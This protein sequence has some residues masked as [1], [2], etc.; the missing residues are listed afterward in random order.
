MK[1][2]FLI[3]ALVFILLVIVVLLIIY[4]PTEEEKDLGIRKRL[5]S[6][7]LQNQPQF[8]TP[9]QLEDLLKERGMDDE[10]LEEIRRQ[11]YQYPDFSR[12]LDKRMIDLINFWY[13]EAQPLP[14]ILNPN[15]RDEKKISDYIK[16]LQNEGKTES[17][18]QKLIEEEFKSYPTYI[19]QT[20]KHT[21]TKGDVLVATL[22]IFDSKGNLLPYDVIEAGIFADPYLKRIRL[23]TPEYNDSGIEPDE[24]KDDVYTF[25]WKIPSEDKKYWGNLTLKVKVYLQEYQNQFEISETFFSSPWVVAEFLDQF[26]EEIKDGHLYI[27]AFLKVNKECEYHIQANLFSVEFDEPTHWVTYKNIL[28]PGIHKITFQF[29]GKIFHDKEVEGHFLLKD[30][31]GYCENLPFPPSWFLDPTKKDFIVNAPPKDEP[32]FFYIPY[33]N[34]NY[35]T[36]RYYRLSEFSNEDWLS[37]QK[38]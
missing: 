8:F 31:R 24:K 30:L 16:K 3:L 21:L 36:K 32:L 4:F 33:T 28:S 38:K 18:I 27:S 13:V 6:E 19:F 14:I 10:V 9:E 25:S 23:G 11:F 1:K 2:L 22:K 15:L 37:S 7:L 5:P 26:E 12:P 34:I 20:N 17:E 35:K 29:W